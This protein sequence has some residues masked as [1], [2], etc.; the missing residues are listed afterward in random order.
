MKLKDVNINHG[1][2]NAYFKNEGKNESYYYDTLEFKII[3]GSLQIIVRELE[4]LPDE[5][6]EYDVIDFGVVI[7]IGT[8]KG[9]TQYGNHYREQQKII[10]LYI[11]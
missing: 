8:K 1:K 6:K 11:E 9:I 2:I 3:K 4:D 7:I 10:T 5:F